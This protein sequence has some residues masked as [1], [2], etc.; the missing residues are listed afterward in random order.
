MVLHE[1]LTII[2]SITRLPLLPSPP[3]T[4]T[5]I[6]ITRVGMREEEGEEE[7]EEGE[8]C[9]LTVTMEQGRAEEDQGMEGEDLME[10]AEEEEEGSRMATRVREEEVV[11]GTCQIIR[12]GISI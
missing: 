11:T 8:D 4:T 6:G 2:K 12:F 9:S 3:L 10:E 7:E 5:T 1:S